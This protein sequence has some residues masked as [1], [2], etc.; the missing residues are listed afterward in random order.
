ML[1]LVGQLLAMAFV[2]R[3]LTGQ[4]SQLSATTSAYLALFALLGALSSLGMPPGELLSF[5]ST[6]TRDELQLWRV[7]SAFFWV[8]GIGAGFAMQ[9]WL[10]G[11]Y[12][13]LL[14]FRHFA[15]D[16]KYA[17]LRYVGT[18]AAG[19]A[20]ILMLAAA[21]GTSATLSLA[22]P[23][24]FYVVGLWSRSEPHRSFELFQLGSV[25]GAFV[26]WCLLALCVPLTG[27]E[28]A[29]YNVAGIG[30]ALAYELAVGLPP[31]LAEAA[32][33][34]SANYAAA[35]RRG[36]HKGSSSPG[37]KKEAPP[38][39]RERWMRWAYVGVALLLVAYHGGT[40]AA[41]RRAER[42]GEQSP[43]GL[44][45]LSPRVPSSAQPQPRPDPHCS[46]AA[47]A[48]LSLLSHTRTRSP[49]PSRLP[50][51][52]HSPSPSPL[53]SPSPSLLCRSRDAHVQEAAGG[54]RH[55]EAAHVGGP[56]KVHRLEALRVRL[57]RHRRR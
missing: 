41:E 53:P 35:V 43:R 12:S 52:S 15:D 5:D 1:D 25:R 9:F 29:L 48:W 40:R 7:V 17:A 23:L 32:N 26:P 56:R 28:C 33:K 50:S 10:F 39:G 22:H 51:H 14:E 30:A 20:Q 21:L 45:H 38:A 2:V 37:K 19:A 55:V 44:R 31:P 6:L 46:A 57:H 4:P 13:S 42:S 27:L 36:S 54:D 34:F 11:M 49:S 47:S 3:C 24:T 8:D 16:G 18:L